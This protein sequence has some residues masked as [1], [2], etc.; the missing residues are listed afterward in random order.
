MSDDMLDAVAYTYHVFQQTHFK[1][2]S[3]DFM[4]EYTSWQQVWKYMRN[5]PHY[6]TGYVC[7]NNH[8][9]F[10]VDGTPCRTEDVPSEYKA[11][12]L[13]T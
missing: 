11:L 1:V 3:G 4:A 13:I 5:S 9:W 6:Q 8:S 12:A 7:V 2:Y 10:R